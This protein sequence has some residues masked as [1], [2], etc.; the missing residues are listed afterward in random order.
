MYELR[1]LAPLN[2]TRP[3]GAPVQSVLAQPRRTA[4][5]AY[6]AME[7]GPVSRDRLLA[8]FWPESTDERAR[9]ALNQALHFLR[10]SLG[11]EVI[12]TSG[13]GVALVP[14]SI[15]CDAVAFEAACQRGAWEEAGGLYRGD[16]LDG[17]H[18]SDAPD[19]ERWTEAERL[20]LRRR[21]EAMAWLGVETLEGEGKGDSAREWADR[22]VALARGEEA[23]ARRQI[24]LLGRLGDRAA[25]VGAYECLTSH[26]R[27]EHGVPPAEETRALVEGILERGASLPGATPREAPATAPRPAGGGSRGTNPTAAPGRPPRPRVLAAALVLVVALAVA[28]W[29]TARGASAF[30]PWSG[31]A[32]SLAV[33]PFENLDADSASEYFAQGVTEEL[34]GSLAQIRSLRVPAWTSAFR[35]DARSE[36]VREVGRRLG[37]ESVLAG[38]IRKSGDRVRISARL[39]DTRSGYYL[40]SGTFERDL[41]DVFAMQ[42]EIARNIADSLRVRLR[43]EDRDRLAR[44][45]TSD[46]AAYLM[47]LRGRHVLKLR[48][49]STMRSAAEHF[50]AALARDP[51]YADA[52]A[53]YAE[54]ILLLAGTGRVSAGEILPDARSAA[55]RALELDPVNVHARV[56]MAG[57]LMQE[58]RWEESDEAFRAA[59]RA[60]PSH[61]TAHHWYSILLTQ[62]GRP[63]E[64]VRH[65]E[66]AVRADPLSTAAGNRLAQALYFVGRYEDAA[67]QAESM[68]QLEPESRQLM[69]N[70]AATYLAMGRPTE[71]ERIL[72]GR[73]KLGPSPITL[74]LLASTYAATGRRAE[75]LRI[76]QE[77]E[78]QADAEPLT[79]L[80]I[81]TVH[82]ALGEHDRA[83]Q[84]LDRMSWYPDGITLLRASHL[85]APLRLDPRYTA[86]LKRLS[87][88]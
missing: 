40:W 29:W 45:P 55:E 53:G 17:F 74:S 86:I 79:P 6:L 26:L 21:M 32:R 13:N 66:R 84:W 48:T 58:R 37:V 3:D 50:A 14:E 56:V 88:D 77:L 30:D 60:S 72:Q 7:P 80:R 42:E 11:D 25:V 12:V 31:Q 23:A 34:L 81:A 64:A 9:N 70:L 18:I 54:A 19:F 82:V 1:L 20:R 69:N 39:I 59:I 51:G 49:P 41:T 65:A 75:A 68:L 78:G 38:S 28:G 5:L 61:A 27:D 44:R 83:F 63:E 24:A 2:L 22:A 87:V 52:H 4:L 47:Y 67:Q 15:R 10:R 46:S 33:L 71:A 8:M 36:D 16:F 35:I 57:I 73:L 85:L 62:L 43:A 76:L